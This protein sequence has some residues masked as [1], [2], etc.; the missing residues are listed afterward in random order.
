MDTLQYSYIL[1]SSI[2]GCLLTISSNVCN[3]FIVYFSLIIF[4]MLSLF[5]MI[6]FVVY[7]SDI[8]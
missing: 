3:S 7:D 6:V 8:V 5:V 4:V 1:T 2:Y